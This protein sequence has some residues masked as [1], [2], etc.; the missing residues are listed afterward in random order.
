MKVIVY[1]QNGFMYKLK[2][3]FV[4]ATLTISIT[5]SFIPLE[6]QL[7]GIQRG[8][9]YKSTVYLLPDVKS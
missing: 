9:P 3:L 7:N 4:F 2:F 1:D 5:G 6:K 8:A